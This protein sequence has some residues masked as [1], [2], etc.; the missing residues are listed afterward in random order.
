MK[1]Y[2]IGAA[3]MD[4][5]ASPL[6]KP[7]QGES[8]PVNT[9]SCYG[10]VA[11]NF[12]ENFSIMGAEPSLLSLVG[13]DAEGTSLISN[14][15]KLGIDVSDILVSDQMPTAKYYALLD[16]D[17]ELFVATADM[18]IYDHLTPE[19]VLP[20]IS[21]RLDIIDWVIDANLPAETIAAI[22]KNASS[23]QRL[24]GTAV[25]AAKAPRLNYGLPYW[26]GL[27]LNR[28]ELVDMTDEVDLY[29]GVQVLLKEGVKN[30]VVTA[31]ADGVFYSNGGAIQYVPCPPVDVVEVTGA[32]DAFC[33]CMI[34]LL[35]Q[36][37]PF[38]KAIERSFPAAKKALL[39][40]SSSLAESV[41]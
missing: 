5:K 21:R 16:Q 18:G 10:G 19:K 37:L 41:L 35:I 40:T 2:C 9:M 29:Q 20:K 28:S 23:H 22:T 15:S 7:T 1:I 38:D 27:F 4:V 32:G 14:L 39:S 3:H 11:R 34:Y 12:A 26:H 8:I 24:W 25:S 36:G 17:G 6:V 30:V 13:D 33:A 31:G